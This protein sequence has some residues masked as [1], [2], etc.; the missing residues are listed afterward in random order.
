MSLNKCPKCGKEVSAK[1]IKCVHCGLVLKPENKARL[2]MTPQQLF[3]DACNYYK[4]LVLTIKRVGIILEGVKNFDYSTE[5]ALRQIDWILQ[6]ILLDQALED[7]EMEKNERLFIDQITKYGDLLQLINEKYQTNLQWGALEILN[8]KVLFEIMKAM[9][10]QI[11]ELERDFIGYFA[12]ADAL[13][14]DHDYYEDLRVDI[15]NIAECLSLV[16]GDDS[17]NNGN[18]LFDTFFG[19][20]YLNKKHEFE[21][22]YLTTKNKK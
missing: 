16:N 6:F 12:F 5:I 20:L 7:G 1:A 9:V 21:Q 8:N 19:E 10:P 22:K 11:L 2:D 13:I 4:D 3:D 14:E 18:E 15:L 17:N